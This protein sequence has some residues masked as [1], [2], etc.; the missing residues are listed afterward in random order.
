MEIRGQPIQLSN[1]PAGA[2]RGGFI[3]HLFG[4][5][6]SCSV[7]AYYTNGPL[8]SAA[9]WG[10]SRLAAQDDCLNLPG[11]PARHEPACSHSTIT[12]GM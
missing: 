10:G 8:E 2:L 11:A 7:E 4:T 9:Q 3:I 12:L 1:L 6:A 5:R